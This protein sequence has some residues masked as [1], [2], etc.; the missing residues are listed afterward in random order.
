MRIGLVYDLREEYRG[1]GLDEEAL[2]EFDHPE[3]LAALEGALRS[4]GHQ[5][6]RVGSLGALAAALV[7]GRRWELV[8]NIAEGLRGRGREAAV[9]ALLEA[10]DLPYLFSDPL[11]MAVSL[12]KG[13]C[14][15]LV[16]EAGLPTAP[17]CVLESEADLR[18]CALP[19]PLFLKPVAE[20]SGKGCGA[21]SLVESPEGFATVFRRLRRRFAQP[22]LVEP[23][24][25]GREFT[26]GIVGNQDPLPLHRVAE[27]V[28]REPT[29]A[30]PVYSFAAKEESL[31][32]V[33]YRPVQDPE[34]MQALKNGLAIYRL[35][36]CRDAGRLDF[37]SDAAGVPQFLEINPL[38]GLH[39]VRSGLPILARQQ[40]WSYPRLIQSMVEVAMG[41]LFPPEAP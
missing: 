37:R 16:R 2:A 31:R 23:F 22:V 29:R 12:D 30:A 10:Y 36:G 4:A 17:F 41:R 25:P 34:A 32:E 26:V 28:F 5:V 8:F 39:P 19:F 38:A 33:L 14:K 40:G 13:V 1:L 3:T 11:T 27:I 6:E 18:G 9:P 7:A 35:V 20:G 24:L 15:R 21:G